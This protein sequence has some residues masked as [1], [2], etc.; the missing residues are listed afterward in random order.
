[1]KLTVGK[2]RIAESHATIR[3]RAG[4]GDRERFTPALVNVENQMFQL[5][6]T[7]YCKGLGQT[8]QSRANCLGPFQLHFDPLIRRRFLRISHCGKVCP[9]EA[10]APS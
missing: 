6:G 8:E 10:F 3:L 1:M 9:E 4:F 7:V 2:R 5:G